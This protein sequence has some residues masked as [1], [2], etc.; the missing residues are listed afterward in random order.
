MLDFLLNEKRFFLNWKFEIITKYY[1][2]IFFF[3]DVKA[4]LFYS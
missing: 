3:F 1:F 4:L 2:Y